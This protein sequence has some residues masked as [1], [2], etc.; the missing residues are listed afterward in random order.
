MREFLQAQVPEPVQVL[1]VR[2]RPLSLGHIILLH[3]FEC[4]FLTGGTPGFDDLVLGILICSQTFDDF[5]ELADSSEFTATIKRLRRK[6]FSGLFG[7]FWRV[8]DV[9]TRTRIFVDYLKDGM[10]GPEYWS[11]P[12]HISTSNAPGWASVKVSLIRR[13]GMTESEALNRPYRLSLFDLAVAAEQ[14]G[15]IRIYDAQKHSAAKSAAD[16]V[17]R[18]VKS[19]ELKI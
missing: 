6:W 9:A 10:T 13:F 3:R 18:R 8:P 14:D 2:L 17:D 7:F 4:A 11:D 15:M 5:V 12:K 19:G 1:G 16:E